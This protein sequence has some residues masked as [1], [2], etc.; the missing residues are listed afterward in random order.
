[1]GLSPGNRGALCITL[2]HA[3]SA[4]RT[5]MPQ[6]L[7][8]SLVY[9]DFCFA[10]SVTKGFLKWMGGVLDVGNIMIALIEIYVSIDELCFS[11][12]LFL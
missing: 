12:S 9:A 1:M 8:F 4:M 5:W 11:T 6:I 7:V 3:L 10:S 2:L